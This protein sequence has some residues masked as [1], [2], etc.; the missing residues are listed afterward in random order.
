[1]F[2][3]LIVYLLPFYL[4]LIV[5]NLIFP[6]PGWEVLF[7]FSWVVILV[8]ATVWS[9]AKS[10]PSIEE[11]LAPKSIDC[12]NCEWP[13][14]AERV[15]CLKCLHALYELDEKGEM[16]PII[17]PRSVEPLPAQNDSTN[18]SQ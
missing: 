16:T 13:N 4:A 9:I 8:V 17:T 18:T 3:L 2:R 12:P 7:H 6:Q 11:R 10:S 1:M 14:P 15:L 5:L